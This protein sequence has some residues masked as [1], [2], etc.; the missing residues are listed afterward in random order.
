MDT[1]M[2]I[3]DLTYLWDF[4]KDRDKYVIES[5]YLDHDFLFTP[6]MEE[7]GG[8]WVLA[9]VG[10]SYSAFHETLENKLLGIEP[11][12]ADTAPQ[13]ITVQ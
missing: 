7:Y 8:A 1:N 11:I 9:P 13:P 4:Y 2:E 10:G 3:A 12:P 5:L 6:P